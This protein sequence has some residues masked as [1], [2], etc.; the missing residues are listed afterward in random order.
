MSDN[1]RQYRAI[2][3]AL[4]QGYPATP[5]GRMA[6]HVTT[7]AA[8]IRGIVAS[9]R[10]HLPAVAA[11]VPDGAH[12]ESRVKRLTRW[13]KNAQVTP[14]VSFV[15]FATV[16]LTHLA[17]QTLVLLREGSVVGRGGVALRLPVVSKGRAV[18]LAWGVRQGKKGH[19]PADQHSALVQEVH[20]LIPAGVPV[21]LLGDG[22][23]DGTSFPHT[24]QTDGWSSVV[25][26]GSNM[27]VLWDRERFRCET[28]G[29]CIKPGTRVTLRDARV[30]DAA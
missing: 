14:E 26:T 12:P 18:P 13:L 27:T 24:L 11:P 19:V 20:Q 8:L 16:F 28:I 30:T 22:E 25:R 6:Q 17:L 4:L 7:L 3:D 23:F 1:L 29:A 5:T 15:P 9:K 2:R 10:T 21:V